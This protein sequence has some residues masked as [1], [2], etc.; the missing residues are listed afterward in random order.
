MTNTEIFRQ[1]QKLKG[2]NGVRTP[3]LPKVNKKL[4][5]L[6]IDLGK[7]PSIARV[8]DK[9]LKN[10]T[11]IRIWLREEEKA[12]IVVNMRIKE[13]FKHFPKAKFPA[14]FEGPFIQIEIPL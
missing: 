2:V 9:T 4:I 11:I 10:K 7:S 14:D 13:M 3:Y 6:Y 12:N 1:Q 8:I 5:G